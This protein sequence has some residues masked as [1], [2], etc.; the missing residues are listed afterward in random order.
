MMIFAIFA[1]FTA[2][3]ALLAEIQKETLD[4]NHLIAFI[5]ALTVLLTL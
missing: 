1:M 2:L 4:L 5:F 3:L